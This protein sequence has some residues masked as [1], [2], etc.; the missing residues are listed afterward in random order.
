MAIDFQR[1]TQRMCPTEG[2]SAQD[3]SLWI[4]TGITCG[5]D[6]RSACALAW[7]LHEQLHAVECSLQSPS[8][9]LIYMSVSCTDRQI[10]IVVEG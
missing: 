1:T 9:V 4:G 3:G 2:N 8:A 7:S 6:E 10:Q 5:R